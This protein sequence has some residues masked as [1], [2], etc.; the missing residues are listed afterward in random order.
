M[1][2][3]LKQYNVSYE[4]ALLSDNNYPRESTLYVAVEDGAIFDSRK[5]GK[6]Q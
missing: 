3:G 1:K 5:L 4:V 6:C 2:Y